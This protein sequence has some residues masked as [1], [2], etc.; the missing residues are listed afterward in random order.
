MACATVTR[1]PASRYSIAADGVFDLL[2]N[3]NGWGLPKRNHNDPLD[4][5]RA[6]AVY[7]DYASST[8][9]GGVE[10]AEESSI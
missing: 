6:A 4:H 2:V 3:L 5:G 1:F 10:L 7:G 9:D 8:A